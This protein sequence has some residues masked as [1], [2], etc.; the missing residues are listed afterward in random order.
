MTEQSVSAV[1]VAMRSG[2]PAR[3]PSPKN[4]PGV[5][6]AMTA[7]LPCRD[8]TVSLTFPRW[9]KN[10][11]SAGSPCVKITAPLRWSRSV[12]PLGTAAR[13][14]LPSKGARLLSFM[15]A[16]RLRFIRLLLTPIIAHPRCYADAPM[17]WVPDSTAY[18]ET[19][20][21]AAAARPHYRPLV[22]TL[23]SFTQTEID[24]RERL[25]KISLV[26]Q[27]ITFTVYGEKDGIE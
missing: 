21:R 27:G 12:R 14:A 20:D 6:R 2:W 16:R 26:D 1:A 4:S 5:R 17:K 8:R 22:A 9:T 24:R 13:S 23:E 19:F 7:C 15:L 10:T 3:Q 18:D 11:A 25:Q